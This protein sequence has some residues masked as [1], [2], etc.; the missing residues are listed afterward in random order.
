M[1]LQTL[2]M[3]FSKSTSRMEQTLRGQRSSRTSRQ[4]RDVI[5]GGILGVKIYGERLAVEMASMKTAVP[6]V[7]AVRDAN[8]DN[9]TNVPHAMYTGKAAVYVHGEL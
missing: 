6:G 3:T 5:S 7:Y 2:N 9:S 1:S 8:S 4:C